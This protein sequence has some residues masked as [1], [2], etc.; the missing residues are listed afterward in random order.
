M[1]NRI[2]PR[3][4]LAI[5]IAGIL[6]LTLLAACQPSATKLV[7]WQHDWAEALRALDP[8]NANTPAHD[9]TAVYLREDGDILQIRIDLLDF[10]NPKDVSMEI[11]IESDSTPQP[12]PL[13]IQIPTKSDSPRISLDPLLATVTIDLP[14]SEIPSRPRIDI[15]TPEDQIT[16]LTLDSPFPTQIAPLLLTFYDTFTGRFPAEALRSWDG[17]H[18]GPRGERHGLKHLLDAVEEYQVPVVL[19][20][21]KEP[22]NLS[23]LDAMGVLPQIEALE[24]QGL[25]TLPKNDASDIRFA[26]LEDSSHLYRPLF[27]EITY[28]PLATETDEFQPTSNGPSMEVRRALLEIALNNDKKDLLVLGGNFQETTWGSP[29]MVGKTMAYFASRPYFHILNKNDLLKFPTKSSNTL[30]PQPEEPIDEL[31]LHIHSILEFA[32]SWAEGSLEITENKCQAGSLGCIL[33]NKTYLAIFDSQTA[34]LIFLFTRDETSLHQLIGPSWQVAP[35]IDLYPGA[36]GDNEEYDVTIMENTLVFRSTDGSRTKTFL[37]GESG[38]EVNYQTDRPV[39]VQIPLLVDPRTRF[40]PGWAEKYKQQNTP[41]GIAWGL[42]NG[43]KVS[44][45]TEGAITMRTFN[46]SLDLLASSEDP[47]FEYPPGHYVPFPMAVAEVKMKDGYFLR[48]ERL[49]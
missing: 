47:D 37:L 15:S 49:P 41:N 21:L 34:S 5:L 42:E 4:Q 39:P 8:A 46:E 30:I 7:P 36:F 35:V 26:Y 22:E 40:T 31:S 1:N 48:L 45:Q 20:D 17:A 29:D 23:A 9:I 2:T 3:N 28:I 24:N 32:N 14:L 13:I 6:F 19:L 38:L 27:K 11:R 16:G 18:T 12:S 33:V 25:L 43:M 44:V 10:K